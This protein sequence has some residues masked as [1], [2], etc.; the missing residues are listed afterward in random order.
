MVLFFFPEKFPCGLKKDTKNTE[1][2]P[3]YVEEV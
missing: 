2:Y 1:I 3:A